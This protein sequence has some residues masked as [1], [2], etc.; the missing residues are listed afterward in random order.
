MKHL[1][2]TRYLARRIGLTEAQCEPYRDYDTRPRLGR[3]PAVVLIDFYVAG[4]RR[5]GA[6]AERAVAH[7]R[8][9][10]ALARGRGWPCVW[11]TRDWRSGRPSTLRLQTAHT[12]AQQRDRYSIDAR[13]DPAGDPVISK[14][15]A[16][17]YTDTTLDALLGGWRTDSV[18]YAG[19]STAGCVRATVTEG[20]SRH[21]PQV[22]VEECVFCGDDRAHWSNLWDM[23]HRYAPVIS[24]GELR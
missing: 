7:T 24:L 22:I 8:E 5:E 10:V 3:R 4:V 12:Q 16:S 14:P 6:T 18:I 20:F 23:H 15:T 2:T 17:A 9:L 11:I 19:H 13:L 1:E 21:R